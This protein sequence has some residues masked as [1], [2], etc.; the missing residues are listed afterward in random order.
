MNAESDA[1]AQLDELIAGDWYFINLRLS[2]LETQADEDM[3]L[4]TCR[5]E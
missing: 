1:K 3:A 4:G 5:D 2:Y